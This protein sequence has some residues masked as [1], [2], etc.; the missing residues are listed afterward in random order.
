[1]VMQIAGFLASG[2]GGS[3]GLS[4]YTLYVYFVAG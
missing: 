4:M 2:G 3:G 1:M